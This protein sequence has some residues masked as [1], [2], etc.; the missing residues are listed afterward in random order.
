MEDLADVA[1][2]ARGNS[3]ARSSWRP[4][5][6][7]RTPSSRCG[8]RPRATCSGPQT[9]PVVRGGP[10][11]GFGDLE[12]M[13]RAF[14]R[15]VGQPPQS[16]CRSSI[17][18]GGPVAGAAIS[19]ALH[20]DS[21]SRMVSGTP[22]PLDWLDAITVAAGVLTSVLFAAGRATVGIACI[23]IC[24]CVV[25]AIASRPFWAVPPAG[26]A[27]NVAGFL[28]YVAVAASLMPLISVA[29]GRE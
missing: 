26:V 14:L 11:T 28:S 22:S 19:V 27:E 3:A 7:R 20:D 16:Q 17:A 6:L 1:N 8:S 25:Q 2:S 4:A 15:A 9:S 29:D 18:Q 10:R 13:R 24:Y 21:W 5:N 12:R 23:W